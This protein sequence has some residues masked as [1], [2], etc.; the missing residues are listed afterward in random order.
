ILSD[1]VFRCF[2]SSI[3]ILLFLRTDIIFPILNLVWV[4]LLHVLEYLGHTDSSGVGSS[5]SCPCLF[6]SLLSVV[7]V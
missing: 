6:L 7:G 2:I 5:R 3:L 4:W 1:L